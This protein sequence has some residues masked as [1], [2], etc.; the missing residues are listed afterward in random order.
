MTILATTPPT[1]QSQAA[2]L[3]S[4][5]ATSLTFPIYVPAESVSAY[6]TAFTG[7]KNRIQAIPEN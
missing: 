6:K 4:L 7:Y 1:L 3:G 2:A 5:G